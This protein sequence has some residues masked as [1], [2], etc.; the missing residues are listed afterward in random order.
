MLPQVAILNEMGVLKMHL[1]KRQIAWVSRIA[2]LWLLESP[3]DCSCTTKN[4]S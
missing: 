2:Q 1:K 3:T 4:A